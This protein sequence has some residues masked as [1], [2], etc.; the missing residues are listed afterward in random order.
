M[1]KLSFP[2]LVILALVAAAVGLSATADPAPQELKKEF[3]VCAECHEDVCT[4][5]KLVRH[6]AIKT[7]QWTK[8]ALQVE[9]LCSNC[10]GD[11]AKHLE[12][13]GGAGTIF[14]FRKTDEPSAKADKCLQ[15]HALTRS[16]FYASPHG[17]AAMDCTSCHSEVMK[18][19][20]EIMNP[21]QVCLT[22]HQDIGAEFALNER[23]R[24]QEGVMECT[25]CHNQHE[26]TTRM[27]LA[28]FKD[29]LCI[30]CHTDKGGPFLYE[31]EA[32]RVEGCA[33]CHEVHGSHNRHM[34][35]H[36]S[37]ADL[38]FSCHAAAPA[39]HQFFTPQDTNCVTCHPTIH[40]S[41]L[42]RRFLK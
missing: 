35:N 4:D 7:A 20:G 15:C 32:S 9:S 14:A 5:F 25:T 39:F 37:T 36:Q 3:G 42:S 27:R 6:A 31:H 23:H 10:H 38:C 12:A 30:S 2:V 24:L 40:G 29:E 26:P 1:L 21:S 22:C 18:T 33:S 19:G 8:T 34:L 13:G 17:K 41:N 11:P 16:R 28:G